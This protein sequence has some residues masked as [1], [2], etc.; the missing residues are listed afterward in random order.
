MRFRHVIYVNF[1]VA[2]NLGVWYAAHHFG[3]VSSMS[4]SQ[5]ILFGAIMGLAF[6]M[7][8]EKE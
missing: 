4:Q 6:A 8:F 2:V 7:D 1:G 5:A 3:F